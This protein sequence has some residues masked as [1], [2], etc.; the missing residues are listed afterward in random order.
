MFSWVAYS[1][2]ITQEI[3]FVT[4][5]S[6][7]WSSIE[8]T[9]PL[10][11][12]LILQSVCSALGGPIQQVIGISNSLAISA[13]CLGGGLV[14][15]GLGIYCHSLSL[16]FGGYGLGG[17]GLGI[18]LAPCVHSL[19]QSLPSWKGFAS[20]ISL[21]SLSAAVIGSIP[22]SQ[23][24]MDSYRRL[25]KSISNTIDGNEPVTNLIED[26]LYVNIDGAAIQVFRA[27]PQD[28]CKLPYQMS[29]GLYVYGSGSTGA[30]AAIATLGAAQFAILFGSSYLTRGRGN[31]PQKSLRDIIASE[32]TGEPD[33]HHDTWFQIVKYVP[34][35]YLPN[36]AN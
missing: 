11:V 18:A 23:Y 16:V 1:N 14:M 32:S 9:F 34:Y 10:Q 35:L 21:A 5:S 22:L 2:V 33:P 31:S 4:S 17:M 26:K 20:G 6:V 36:I 25:P 27:L 15:S 13:S 12:A 24:L 8:T 19:M 28:L 29:E 7:D 30:A 3:G